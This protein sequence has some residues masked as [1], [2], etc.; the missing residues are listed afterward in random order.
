MNII[1]FSRALPLYSILYSIVAFRHVV[2]DSSYLTDPQL[3]QCAVSPCE[4][5]SQDLTTQ[6][7]TSAVH[8][9]AS[10]SLRMVH[11]LLVINENY[12]W[13]IGGFLFESP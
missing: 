5:L 11:V 13:K 8:S 10:D 7:Q 2:V 9:G 3:E 4:K 6:R 12:W 1:T